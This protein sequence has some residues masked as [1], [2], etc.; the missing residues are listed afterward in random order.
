MSP[1]CDSREPIKEMY[2]IG[3]GG[4]PAGDTTIFDPK[5]KLFGKFINN[6]D[7]KTTVSFD[8]GHTKTE[9]LIGKHLAKATNAGPFIKETYEKLINEM[10]S[11]I[12]SGQL[13]KGDQLMITIDTHGAKN[14][15]EKTHEISLSGGALTDLVTLEGAN[16]VN[17]DALEKLAALASEKQ[18]KLAILDFSCFSGNLLNIKNDKVCMISATSPDLFARTGISETSLALSTSSFSDNFYRFMERGS[19]LEDLFLK[20]FENQNTDLDDFS[21]ISS[22]EGRAAHALLYD[23]LRPFL[24]FKYNINDLE[25]LFCNENKEYKGL[26]PLL[27]QVASMEKI[28]TQINELKALDK[29]LDL[30]GKYQESYENALKLAEKLDSDFKKIIQRDYPLEFDRLKNLN[31]TFFLL[32]NNEEFIN[33]FPKDRP[34]FKKIIDNMK[35]DVQIKKEILA[36]LGTEQKDALKTIADVHKTSPY[37]RKLAGDIYSEIKKIFPKIYRQISKTTS[38][39]CSDFVL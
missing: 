10:I 32:S 15:G 27:E 14:K 28:S 11:K 6:S 39:P 12:E 17:L 34:E 38:N 21:M 25:N 31:G 2:Y 5:I 24:T 4:E 29:A 33:N 35:R 23:L 20:A 1:N 18:V 26:R 13:R 7:W 8:G 16:T 9:A 22:V 19:N 37:T 30:Y 3:A 36:K